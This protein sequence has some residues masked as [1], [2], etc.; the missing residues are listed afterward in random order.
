MYQYCLIKMVI[1]ADIAC[2]VNYES[3]FFLKIDFSISQVCAFFH[4]CFCLKTIK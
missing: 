2:K 1:T 4:Y 3:N